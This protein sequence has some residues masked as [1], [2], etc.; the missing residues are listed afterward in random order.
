MT[1]KKTALWGMLTALAFILGYLETLLP[2]SIAIP[3]AKLGLANLVVLT[4]LYKLGYKDAFLLNIIRILL[5]AFTFGNIMSL[6]MSL[7]GGILSYISMAVA[8]KTGKA[9]V[10]F[11]S[12]LGGVTHNIGQIAAAAI[13]V[14]NIYV[15]AYFPL[16]LLVGIIS[17]TL[18]GIV[19]NLLIQRIHYHES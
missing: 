10:L 17:G 13:V 4:A 19:G 12:I 8:K 15:L 6:A 16:L 14:K 1:T 18:I 3:G 9:S 2:F 5:S 7:A 11:V